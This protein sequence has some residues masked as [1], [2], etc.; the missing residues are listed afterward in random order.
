[1]HP[2][3][4]AEVA[5]GGDAAMVPAELP[6]LEDLKTH[7][8]SSRV[9]PEKLRCAEQEQ[10][11]KISET[12]WE[13]A[14]EVL[15]ML[16]ERRFGRGARLFEANVLEMVATCVSV[17]EGDRE[18]KRRAQL[19]AIEHAFGVSHGAPTP[20]YIW[21]SIDHFLEHEARGRTARLHLERAQARR[22]HAAAGQRQQARVRS[23]QGEEVCGITPQ[24]LRFIDEFGRKR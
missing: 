20:S 16:R 7:S 22:A 8:S 5:S 18:A 6:D 2:P 1:M 21:G 9:G 23:L 4:Q 12:D 10:G 13:I 17:V 15:A 11:S 24:A 19:D 14:F 3:K